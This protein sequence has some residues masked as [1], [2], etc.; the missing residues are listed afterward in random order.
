MANTIIAHGITIEG[1]LTSDDDVVIQQVEPDG[2]G[3]DGRPG[4]QFETRE[5]LGL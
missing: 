1:E 5:T 3:W 2:L 4:A